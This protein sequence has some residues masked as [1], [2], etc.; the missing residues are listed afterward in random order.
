MHF[1]ESSPYSI[2]TQNHK[3]SIRKSKELMQ[4]SKMLGPPTLVSS[5]RQAP[6][7][8]TNPIKKPELV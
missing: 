6:P 7:S 4:Q 8:Q 5:A 1:G 3:L 2:N